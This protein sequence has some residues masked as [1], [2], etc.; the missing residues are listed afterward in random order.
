MKEVDIMATSIYILMVDC[1]SSIDRL[2]IWILTKMMG[3]NLWLGTLT[4]RTTLM[5]RP[6]KRINLMERYKVNETTQSS[7]TFDREGNL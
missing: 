7:D 6:A 3:S 2:N 5:K 1:L 4:G